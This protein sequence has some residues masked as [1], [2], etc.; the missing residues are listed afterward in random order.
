MMNLWPGVSM[1]TLQWWKWLKC[2]LL[3]CTHLRTLITPHS[4]MTL[5]RLSYD[6]TSPGQDTWPLIGRESSRDLDTGLRFEIIN[7]V[8]WVLAS[9]WSRLIMWPG[10]WPLIGQKRS[11]D[12]DTGL[13]LVEKLV[14]NLSS[15]VISDTIFVSLK[16]NSTAFWFFKSVTWPRHKNHFCS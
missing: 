6:Q 16:K 10:H 5:Q 13:S 9:D 7:N 4:E 12:P 2:W 3:L 14:E 8:T 1:V 15:C 11:L